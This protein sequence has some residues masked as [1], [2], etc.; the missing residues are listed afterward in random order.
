M[1]RGVALPAALLALTLTSALAVGGAYVARQH[2]AMA[3]TSLRGIGLLP[4]AE[5]ALVTAIA[6]WDS[7][8]MEAQPLGS[9]VSLLVTEDS[10]GRVEVWATRTARLQF[11]LVAQASGGVRPALRQRLGVVVTTST[12]VPRVAKDRG[13][14]ALP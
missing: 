8:S 4:A 11:W 13:W 7:A 10:V 14:A 6:L 1:K 5:A 3:R 12:G 2:A 9:V